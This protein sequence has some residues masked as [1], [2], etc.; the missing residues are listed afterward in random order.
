[1]HHPEDD[2]E[3]A[4]NALRLIVREL[5]ATASTTEYTLGISGAQLFVLRE[6]AAEPNISIRRLSE[7]TLTDPS[8]VSVVVARLAARKLVARRADPSDARKSVLSLTPEG[9]TLLARAPQPF[10]E[11]LVRALRDL[12]RAR[13]R[14]LGT[15]LHE[16]I[17]GAGV[18]PGVAPMFFDDGRSRRG[19][20]A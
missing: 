16:I 1:M 3:A 4:L 10:Q 13:L 5:R 19:R 8:S 7:R 20:R 11:R 14:R 9:R 18:R 12:P 6:L 15:D 17:R 2:A